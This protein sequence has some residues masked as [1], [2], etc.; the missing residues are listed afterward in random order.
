MADPVRHVRR[1]LGL[2]LAAVLLAGCGYG[3]RGNLPDHIKTVAVPIFR[4]RTLEPGVETAITSGVVNAFSSGGRVRVVPLDEADAILEGEVVGYSLDGLA[5]DRNA[6]V[7][8]Y[9]L[10]LV[11]NVEFRDV[12]RSAMLWRQE[13]LQETSDFQVAGS[14]SDTVARGQ[15]AVLQAASEIGRKVVNLAV[16]RF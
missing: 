15:G 10:R 9:R 4:N 8:A 6:N 16:D 7:Q 13:G 14:V 11:L 1:A 3:T 2:A 12:R 5:F